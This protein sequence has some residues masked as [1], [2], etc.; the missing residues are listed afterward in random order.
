MSCTIC[1]IRVF[2]Y[3]GKFSI[4]KNLVFVLVNLDNTLH[5]KYIQNFIQIWR[6][7]WWIQCLINTLKQ[8]VFQV[9]SNTKRYVDLLL[10]FGNL[11]PSTNVSTS[12]TFVCL[13]W[14]LCVL[15]L[16][17]EY[18]L[19]LRFSSFFASTVYV[20]QFCAFLVVLDS[21]NIVN[22]ACITLRKHRCSVSLRLQLVSCST[23]G[24]S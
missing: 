1:E 3:L 10:R 7:S 15:K 13:F 20:A 5:V 22:V 9:V 19:L 23:F 14:V 17:T 2:F 4:C 11:A 8:G 16:V 21:G 18:W 6:S 24:S 12:L